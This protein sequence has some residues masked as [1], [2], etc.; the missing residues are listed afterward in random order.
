MDRATPWLILLG[1][2]AFG[3]G[4]LVGLYGLWSS[5]TWRVWDKLL[6]TFIWPGGLLGTFYLF[7]TSSS[8]TTCSGFSR[9]GQAAPTLTCVHH[10]I[11]TLPH[12]L[13]F[14]TGFVIVAA[15]FFT[16]YRLSSVLS[17]GYADIMNPH[18]MRVLKSARSTSTMV[19]VT[20]A[21]VGLIVTNFA[22][23]VFA[24]H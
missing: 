22:I 5:T 15:P 19:R 18:G 21:I 3:F 14:L 16:S 8:A 2:F 11:A 6:G 9:A 7:L 24:L 1:G 4:W 12:A 23:L 10:G 20:W 17:R 13:Q